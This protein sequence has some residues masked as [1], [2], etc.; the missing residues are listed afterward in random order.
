MKIIIIGDIHGRDIWKQII[1]KEKPNKV[2]FLGD[3][4]DSFDLSP[5]TQSTNFDQIVI[6]K[7]ETD[8]EIVMLYGNHEHH[9]MRYD[10]GEIY[11]G[12]QPNMASTYK[13]QIQ[14][15]IQKKYLRI[16][17]LHD[18][19]LF[20]HAGVSTVWLKRELPYTT[21]DTLVADINLLF[22]TDMKAF[23]FA[24]FNP[25]GDSQISSPIW[26]RET[27]LLRSNRR[28]PIKKRFRQVVGHTETDLNLE[29]QCK[30][31]GGRY[32]MVDA[33]AK[34]QYL[35]YEKKAFRVGTHY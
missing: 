11:S 35:I 9:Y 18:D 23:D 28:Q 31:L 13:Q 26:I 12:F 16:A 34:K 6:F 17:H 33:L 2:I 22:L 32:F 29:H 19:I 15:A 4:F 1:K 25:Y 10:D 14:K 3:Y 21:M 30:K 27:A 7:E 20:T 24:G 8:I 5:G